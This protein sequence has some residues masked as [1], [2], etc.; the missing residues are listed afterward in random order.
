MDWR[1]TG[2]KLREEFEQRAAQ[3][4]RPGDPLPAYVSQFFLALGEAGLR[5]NPVPIID[6]LRSGKPLPADFRETLALY[7]EGFFH[8]PRRGRGHPKNILEHI[9]ADNAQHFFDEWRRENACN[10]VK[11]YGH[12]SQMVD[13]SIQIVIE[14]DPMLA[15]C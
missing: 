8:L 12:R 4:M 13:E 9:A 14:N 1:E 7:F 10:G 15:E 6:Y 2:R 3:A 5:G 11:D